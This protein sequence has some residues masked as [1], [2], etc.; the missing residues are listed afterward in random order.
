MNVDVLVIMISY[1]SPTEAITFSRTC[2]AAEAIPLD[3]ALHTVVLNRTTEQ[4]EKFRDHLLAVPSRQNILKCLT[5]GKGVTWE[6]DFHAN[7]PANAIAD[8]VEGAKNLQ[9]FSCG[10]TENIIRASDGR[11]ASALASRTNLRVLELRDGGAKVVQ[12]LSGLQSP[13]LRELVMDLAS[14][15]NVPWNDLFQPL[16][17]FHHLE[18]LS[19][20]K[21]LNCISFPF[22]FTFLPPDFFPPGLSDLSMQPQLAAFNP[23]T[24]P[25]LPSVRTLSLFNTFIPMSFAATV[26]PNITYLTFRTDRLFRSFVARDS[27]PGPEPGFGASSSLSRCWTHTLKEVHL[28]VVDCTVWPLS[29]RVRWLDF[30]FLPRGYAQEALDAVAQTKSEVLSVAYRI[31]TDNLFWVNLPVIAGNLRFLDV[32]ILEPSGHRRVS[33]HQPPLFSTMS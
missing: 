15:G 14:A 28:A 33:D 4:I 17:K 3:P 21:A 31:D 26:F 8:I 10:A 2:K 16:A 6:I 19:I 13:H 1:L 22:Q 30:D 32:R 25:V 11:L 12:I 5:L 7:D 24:A 27:E 29:C 20:S 9:L 23:Q 18:T